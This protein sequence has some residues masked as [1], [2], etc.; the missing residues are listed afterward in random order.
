MKF[1]KLLMVI[2]AILIASNLVYHIIAGLFHFLPRPIPYMAPPDWDYCNICIDVNH[3]F[4]WIA[5]VGFFVLISGVII[6]FVTRRK[7]IVNP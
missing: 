4:G 3:A 5:V 2:G 1:G 7:T 6:H